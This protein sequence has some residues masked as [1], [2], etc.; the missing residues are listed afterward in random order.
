LDR[1]DSLQQAISIL[2]S[3][4][5]DNM[6][7]PGVLET[8]LR[9]A[10]AWIEYMAGYSVDPEELLKCFED[11]A[12]NYDQ[13]VLV[14]DIP[15]YSTCEHHLAPFFGTAT[16]AY[17]PKGRVVGLSKINR[18]VDAFG[19]RLQVQERMTGQI[20]DALVKHLKPIGVGVVVKARHLCIEARGVGQQG[21]HTVTSA[22]RGALLN[23]PAARAEFFDLANK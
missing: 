20:A 21:H 23:D 11:G 16:V 17:I 19:R 13:M 15:F 10:K 6:D 5:G 18:L 3:E 12:E 7:R 4:S 9:A 14:K 22:L 1:L 8:P 2:L